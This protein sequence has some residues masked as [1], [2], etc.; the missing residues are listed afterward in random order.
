MPENHELALAKAWLERERAEDPALADL[1]A[2]VPAALF[3]PEPQRVSYA[4]WQL[5][6]KT[7]EPARDRGDDGR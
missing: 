7:A 4:H 6:A 3:G 1:L 5:I 2:G